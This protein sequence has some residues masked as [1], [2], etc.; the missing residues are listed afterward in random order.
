MF[1]KDEQPTANTYLNTKP[2]KGEEKRGARKGVVGGL[3]KRG[4]SETGSR[5]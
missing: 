3:Y 4:G 5:G 2:L 1:F